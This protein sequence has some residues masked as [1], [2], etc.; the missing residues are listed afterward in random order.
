MLFEENLLESFHTPP[1]GTVA[2][3]SNDI[4]PKCNIDQCALHV[5]IDSWS[6][7]L[8][9][10][11]ALVALS[12]SIVRSLKEKVSHEGLHVLVAADGGDNMN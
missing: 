6:Y 11:V 7:L 12:I 8:Q 5:S 3:N 4:L 9:E 2:S 1:D 10:W